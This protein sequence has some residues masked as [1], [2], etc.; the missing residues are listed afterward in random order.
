MFDSLPMFRLSLVA[1]VVA[2]IAAVSIQHQS[3][4]VA[5]APREP[6]EA[7]D[8]L[9]IDVP[10]YMKDGIENEGRRLDGATA[11]LDAQ[12]NGWI[13]ERE[14]QRD[15]ARYLQDQRELKHWA[16]NPLLGP[17]AADGVPP[18]PSRYGS[19]WWINWW[20]FDPY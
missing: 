11:V 2:A 10:A 7:F 9:H 20:P 15:Y 18:P 19:R 16:G 13:K 12:T 1:I 14:I 8:V 17:T 3:R 5:N 6:N 4:M